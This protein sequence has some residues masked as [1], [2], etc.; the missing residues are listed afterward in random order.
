MDIEKKEFLKSMD[1]FKKYVDTLPENMKEDL[2]NILNFL[3]NELEKKDN[4]I[5]KLADTIRYY[6]KGEQ[7]FCYD[8]C[9]KAYVKCKCKDEECIKNII[10]K[11]EEK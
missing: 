8:I 11:A 1:N 4:L 3:D 10:K 9:D 2:W 6:K 7:E 5:H